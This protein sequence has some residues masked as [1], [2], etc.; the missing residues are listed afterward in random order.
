MK[1]LRTEKKGGL[2]VWSGIGRMMTDEIRGNRIGVM[3]FLASR[4]T[5]S[6]KA[7]RCLIAPSSRG[8]FL[9]LVCSVSNALFLLAHKE[10]RVSAVAAEDTHECPCSGADISVGSS[11]RLSETNASGFWG[12]S[13]GQPHSS[14]TVFGA[15][16]SCTEHS[17]VEP[18]KRLVSKLPLVFLGGIYVSV[19]KKRWGKL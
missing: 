9:L 1:Q 8:P 5:S 11:Q 12:S 13:H 2:T 6:L 17:G 3:S 16:D 19:M 18:I 14:V 15:I 4:E 10:N 7:R